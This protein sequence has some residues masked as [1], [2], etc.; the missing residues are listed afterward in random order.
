MERAKKG[1]KDVY[2]IKFPNIPVSKFG[3]TKEGKWAN[4]IV[5]DM[6]QIQLNIAQIIPEN[7]QFQIVKESQIDS[8]QG[9]TNFEIVFNGITKDAINL[10]YR[11]YTP[12][13]MARPA[14]YQNLT[15]PIDTEIIRFQNIRIKI[16][17]ISNESI[18]Y[19]VLEDGLK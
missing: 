3:I 7:T 13:N 8:T 16:H 19:T 9:F 17:T 18:S 4:F 15:Y 6:N 14:F 5:G 10:L 2:L 11:E 12:D 1:G